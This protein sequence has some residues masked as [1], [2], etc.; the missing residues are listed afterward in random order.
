MSDVLHEDVE[1]SVTLPDGR[2]VTNLSA[3]EYAATYA[4]GTVHGIG[5]SDPDDVG[6]AE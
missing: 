1:Q 3:E 4:S 5:L 2:V 6:V